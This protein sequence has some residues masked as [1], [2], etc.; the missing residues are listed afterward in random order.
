[1]TR[2][3]GDLNSSPERPSGQRQ[4][5]A[6]FALLV[7][8]LAGVLV[9]AVVA[10]DTIETAA[11]TSG[12]SE[13]GVAQG[14]GSGTDGASTQADGRS[15]ATGPA[16]NVLT[17]PGV[18]SGQQP[19]SN[20]PAGAGPGEGGSSGGEGSGEGVRGVTADTVK[21]GFTHP[22]Y[23][24]LEA[25]D[26]DF[27]TG[28]LRAVLQTILDRWQD[29]GVLPFHGREIEAV[30]R[31]NDTL[32]ASEQR[33]TCVELI[34]D[35]G[36]FAVVSAGEFGVG[37]SCVAEEFNTPI[38]SDQSANFVSTAD[39]DRGAPYRFQAGLATD[40]LLQNWIHWAHHNGHLEGHKLGLY[41]SSGGTQSDPH[42][43]R[44]IVEG[45]LE[46]LGYELAAVHFTD[47]PLGGPDDQ[48]AV[49]KF[50]S[51]QVDMALLPMSSIPQGN[52]MESAQAQ[53]YEP[54]YI[55]SDI[56]W[57]TD[58]HNMKRLPAGQYDGTFAM[59]A[60]HAGIFEEGTLPELAAQ[61]VNDFEER[62]GNDIDTSRQSGEYSY[63]V[64]ACD[65]MRMLRHALENAGRDLTHQTFIGA[66]ETMRNVPM[67]RFGD[68]TFTPNKHHG[69]SGIRSVRWNSDC[70]CYGIV[71]DPAFRPLY[72]E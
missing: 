49:Q 50:R 7:G 35:E 6:L 21:I 69:E 26:P 59:T 3:G 23:D 65:Q 56:L 20:I 18:E 5:G 15:T 67:A 36:V 45:E 51:A 37:V 70:P 47:S 12:V 10:P 63:L 22:D 64:L 71:G 25:I 34:Q 9:T 2:E 8:F 28:D 14:S 41:Y 33:A 57:N 42:I 46:A 27:G 48:V 11:R 68:V 72:V 1:M 13:P 39:M 29:E 32:S 52:F 40:V 38:I 60:R 17:T 55:Q 53:G 66:L 43:T 24:W 54:D 16:S 44:K 30:F 58:D 61:C 31:E 19:S 62:T 4:S